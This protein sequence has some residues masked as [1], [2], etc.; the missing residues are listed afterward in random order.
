MAYMTNGYEKPVL[1]MRRKLALVGMMLLT[2]CATADEI[3]NDPMASITRCGYVL[4]KVADTTDEYVYVFT[5]TVKGA[6]GGYARFA[7]S[8]NM[9]MIGAFGIG[10]GAGG[11]GSGTGRQ[12][13]GAVACESSRLFL[14]KGL[15]IRAF[16]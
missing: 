6:L 11:A 12:V 15:C 3:I 13:G 4:C 14:S 2:V 8:V 1:T 7:P 9:K 10:G 16:A 5:N